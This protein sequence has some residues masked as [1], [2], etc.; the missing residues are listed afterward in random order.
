MIIIFLVTI[1][2]LIACQLLL[3]RFD[4]ILY[5]NSRYV[6]PHYYKSS[7]I[8]NERIKCFSSWNGGYEGIYLIIIK[9]MRYCNFSIC[10]G[11]KVSRVPTVRDKSNLVIKNRD[12]K[13]CFHTKKFITK[14][15]NYY[16]SVFIQNFNY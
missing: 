6:L 11:T 14:F 16:F 12:F 10:M 7:L 2:I 3:L 1:I 15:N 9:Y 5:Q 8:K 4:I 13:E